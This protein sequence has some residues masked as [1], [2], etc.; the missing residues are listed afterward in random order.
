[1]ID[2]LI[3]LHPWLKAGHIVAVIAW[4]AA[5]LYLPRLFVYHLEH[6]SDRPGRHAMFIVMET[7]LLRV[8]MTPAMVLTWTFGVALASLPGAIDWTQ[9]WPWAKLVSV[10]ALTGFHFWL[11]RQSR[12]IEQGNCRISSRQF[13]M[14]NEV[15]TALMILIVVMVVVRPA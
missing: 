5:L 6:A 11:A 10:L 13:R 4:M 14:L 15:P 2:T 3:L 12:M 7:R 8:I 1:M 9:I